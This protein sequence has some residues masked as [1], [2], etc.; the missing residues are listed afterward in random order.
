M[1]TIKKVLVEDNRG[2]TG[3]LREIF[4]EDGSLVVD[5]VRPSLMAEAGSYSRNG[6]LPTKVKSFREELGR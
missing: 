4:D 5:L 2:D 1:K 3:L 6:F